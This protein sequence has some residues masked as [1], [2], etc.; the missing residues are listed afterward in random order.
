MGGLP[1]LGQS[2]KGHQ[3]TILFG[4][5]YYEEYAPY[6]RLDEDVG[7]MK[8][9]GITVVRIAES[10]GEIMRCAS[11]CGVRQRSRG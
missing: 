2:G 5:A 10:T 9:T 1:A 3:D 11:L 4:A 8:A 6:D 7:M